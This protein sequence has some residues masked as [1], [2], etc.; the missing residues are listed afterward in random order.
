MLAGY[1]S[2]SQD[3]LTLKQ[4][5][6]TGIKNN[7][8]VNQSD[9]LM[10]KAD[11]A[12]RQSRSAMLPNLNASADHGTNQGRSIDP[13]TNAFINQNVTYSSRFQPRALWSGS[14]CRVILQQYFLIEHWAHSTLY[15]YYA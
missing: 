4:A 13:F 5:I 3:K 15:I 8:D 10:Q 9:L 6:E 11:V 7:L 2:S 12:F 1:V 14:S